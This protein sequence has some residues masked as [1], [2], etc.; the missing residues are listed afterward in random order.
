MSDEQLMSETV[1]EAHWSEQRDCSATLTLA[2]ALAPVNDNSTPPLPSDVS[3]RELVHALARVEG[4]GALVRP[5]YT[6]V[7][8]G[9]MWWS[10]ATR[11]VRPA[12]HT[13]SVAF[14]AELSQDRSG[15][16]HGDFVNSEDT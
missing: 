1:I 4:V 10:T 2:R 5:D 8:R 15:K 16:V 12:R 9:T 13:R 3:P 6:A 11:P 7:E 14:F